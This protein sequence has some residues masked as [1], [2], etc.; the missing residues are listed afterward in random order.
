MQHFENMPASMM[1]KA[2]T[3]PLIAV[4]SMNTLAA[5]GLASLIGSVLPVAE[6][7]IFHTFLDLP[8]GSRDRFYHYFVT[9]EVLLQN[10]AF[11][12]TRMKRTIVVTAGNMPSQIPRCFR[13]ID[14]T[15]R[16]Q[17]LLRAFLLMVQEAHGGGRLMPQG[18]RNETRAE[19]GSDVLTPR[20]N[21]V[22]REIVSGHINKEIADRLNISLTTV[23][24]H[25]R[26]IMEK[27]HAR[28]VSSL[29]IYAV[30]H[31]IVSVDD[32]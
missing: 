15:Q 23:I 20:E 19:F 32:I 26:N 1:R 27:L 28:S 16:E 2:G 24:S 22:L 11:F 5:K 17:E 13:T 30:M 9:P 7:R 18:V 21:E 25:R 8:E 29:T 31:G 3:R 12:T 10:P 14:A 4:V 6:V